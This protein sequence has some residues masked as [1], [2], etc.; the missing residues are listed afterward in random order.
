MGSAAV[1]DRC[2]MPPMVVTRRPR[3]KCHH[4]MLPSSLCAK[5]SPPAIATGAGFFL[6]LIPPRGVGSGVERGGGPHGSQVCPS[7]TAVGN[8]LLWDE[9]EPEPEPELLGGGSPP[10]FGFG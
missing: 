5:Y 8:A 10:F 9:T 1:D 2:P 7:S 4:C 3:C 6:R